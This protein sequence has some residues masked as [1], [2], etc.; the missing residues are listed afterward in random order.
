M[1]NHIYIGEIETKIIVNP[2]LALI[3]FRT[4]GP[5]DYSLNEDVHCQRN[6]C[7]LDDSFTNL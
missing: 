7:V 4:T 5:R 1:E 3:G 2:G 6:D